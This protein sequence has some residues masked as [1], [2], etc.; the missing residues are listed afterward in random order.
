MTAEAAESQ[1]SESSQ[2]F[3]HE[4]RPEWG[5]AL[6]AWECSDKKAY[7]FD[8]GKMRIFK[9]GYHS[10][11]KPVEVEASVESRVTTE[12]EDTL[13]ARKGERRK[14]LETVYPFSD[15]LKIFDKLYPEG[16]Q[17]EKWTEKHR[18]VGASSRLKRHRQPA[19]EDAREKLGKEDLDELVEA[20]RAG[21]I[22]DRAVAVLKPSNLARLGRVKQ[23]DELEG[24]QRENA[25]EALRDLLYSDIRF[26][27]RFRDWLR[28]LKAGLEKRPSWRLVT[29]L[30]A[31]VHPEDHV[32]VRQ[33][34][35]RREA[36][37]FGPSRLYSR[38]PKRTAYQNYLRISK[39][40]W[41]RLEEEGYSPRDFLDIH[42][43]IWATLRPSA[44]KHLEE[45]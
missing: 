29:A 6:L 15:Q 5:L 39:Q 30:P 27:T 22:I 17:G 12:L 21:E 2:L 41:E 14:P 13:E 38:R 24:E 20:G 45:D 19:L 37:V 35:F 28:A 8:D 3:R 43:F 44:E 42:D 10:F 25:G 9:K 16:F 33:S 4:V 7:Q 40:T 23:L 11:M 1:S 26:G 18:G 32:C 34:A 36:A 31:L